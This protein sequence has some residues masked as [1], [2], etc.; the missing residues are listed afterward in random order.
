MDIVPIQIVVVKPALLVNAR[1]S[2]P[3]QT[4]TTT[5]TTQ[6]NNPTMTTTTTTTA[7]TGSQLPLAKS[8]SKT[9]HAPSLQ[10]LKIQTSSDDDLLE[11]VITLKPIHSQQPQSMA[12]LKE[13][14]S[15]VK[16]LMSKF[17]TK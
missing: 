7:T 12:N 14:R 3:N 1:T 16:E 6:M 9:Y 11:S 10:S 4:T 15:T 2:L 5:T 8:S 17:E 13:K